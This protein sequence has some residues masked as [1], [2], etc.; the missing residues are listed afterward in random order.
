MYDKYDDLY[1]ED[2]YNDDDKNDELAS[3]WLSSSRYLLSVSV[4]V[5]LCLDLK[6]FWICSAVFPLVSGT[7]RPIRTVP[8]NARAAKLRYDPLAPII[9]SSVGE[10]LTTRKEHNQL[11]DAHSDEEA[12]LDSIAK[13]SAFITQGKGPIPIE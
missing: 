11:N 4:S 3:I 7:V 5:C 10:N 13:S 1:D 12:A 6:C 9:N 2:Y 8:R